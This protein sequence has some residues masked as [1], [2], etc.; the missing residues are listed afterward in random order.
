MADVSTPLEVAGL[1]LANRV[2]LAP[3]SG[4]SDVPFRRLARRFGAG[5]VFSEM[6]ASGEYL[7]GDGESTL[8]ALRDGHGIHAVQLAG[9]EAGVMGEAA[10][11]LADAGADLV[12]VNFGCPAKKVVGG[13]SG[14]AL[15]REPELA[16]SIVEAVVA[17]AG[18]VPVTVKMRLGWDRES[19]NAPWLARRAAEAGARLVTVHG[20]TRMDF[21]DGVADWAAIGA[22]RR[23]VGVPLV[24]NG[25]LV[26]PGQ[27]ATM[28]ARSGAD[29]VMVGRGC[30]GR[31][32]LA[33]LMAGAISFDDLAA[34]DFATLVLNH[35]DA[36]L[37]H[38]GIATGVRHARK[39]LSWYL[40]RFSA[41]GGL[42]PPADR[43]AVMTAQEPATVRR[44]L[45]R[46]LA[47]TT[48]A[49]IEAA[50]VAPRTEAA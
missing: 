45:A 20:R 1:R 28:L 30:Y 43:R 36:M 34:T 15:M 9:R 24:A 39:H 26:A 49:D 46:L 33:G 42:V 31:P 25:D 40:D 2:F 21:Y 19:M 41:L 23:A 50:A 4:V 10:R 29:A 37:A 44:C 17:G 38:Y 47:G 3:M 48:P 35:Y 27:I 16:L 11:R 32:W 7:K 13:L 6:V 8:R 5:L 22:V 18:R 14:S 12:D